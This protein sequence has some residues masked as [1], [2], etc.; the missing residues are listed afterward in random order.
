MTSVLSA[1]C[2]QGLSDNE[3]SVIYK[4]IIALKSLVV[5]DLVKKATKYSFLT[6]VR[7]YKV[8]QYNT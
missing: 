1:S 6:E 4:A 8:S 7:F 5:A 3:E 2:L